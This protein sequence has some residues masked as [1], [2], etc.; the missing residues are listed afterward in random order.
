[1]RISLA[2]WKKNWLRLC[3]H[4]DAYTGVAGLA[5]LSSGALSASAGEAAKQPE[6][7]K[8]ESGLTYQDKVKKTGPLANLE[9]SVAP[10][11]FLITHEH[12]T[13]LFACTFEAFRVVVFIFFK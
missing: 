10:V 5:V 7:V 13:Q 12:M 3:S 8:L 6:F 2:P 9:Q 4:V 11:I 1:M